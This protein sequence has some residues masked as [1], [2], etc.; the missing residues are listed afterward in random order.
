MDELLDGSKFI[1]IY[2]EGKKEH[3]KTE[4]IDGSFYTGS[5]ANGKFEG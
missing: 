5:W 2:N 1:G 4:Y 3:G